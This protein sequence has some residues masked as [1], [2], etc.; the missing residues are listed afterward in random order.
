MPTRPADAPGAEQPAE[1]GTARTTPSNATTAVVHR[2][3]RPATLALA[4]LLVAAVA[5]GISAGVANARWAERATEL[6]SEHADLTAALADTEDDEAAAVERAEEAEAAHTELTE[7]TEQRESELDERSAELDQREEDVAAREDAVTETEERIAA[8]RISDGTWTVGDDVEPGTYR[9]TH[10][11][12]GDCYW[13]IY[14]SGTNKRD[15][16][17]NDIVDGGHPTVTL[18]DGQ[19]F[20]SSRCG[21]WDKQ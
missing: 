18:R 7:A 9:T 12:S 6:E 13:G 14:R 2:R 17:A 21:S 8:N 1:S 10:A 11:V 20:E 16:V 19:D 15:I 4:V 5:Y 3:W